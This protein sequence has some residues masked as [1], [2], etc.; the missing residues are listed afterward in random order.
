MLAQLSASQNWRVASWGSAHVYPL[1]T[2]PS[3]GRSY[4]E[5]GSIPGPFLWQTYQPVR[6]YGWHQL[7][8]PMS[9]R[10]SPIRLRVDPTLISEA[11]QVHFFGSVICLYD[12]VFVWHLG[13][14]RRSICYSV[15]CSYLYH[16]QQKHLQS[17]WLRGRIE[18][19]HSS[20]NSLFLQGCDG[21]PQGII[22]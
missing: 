19:W 6:I 15:I 11:S 17:L 7:D 20:L 5:L 3:E 9:I 12:R 13:S 18:I 10:Y 4:P 1:F 16:C 2:H 8:Q 22:K 21:Q 14:W